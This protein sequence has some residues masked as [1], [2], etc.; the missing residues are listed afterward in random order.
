MMQP[1]F[2]AVTVAVAAGFILIK[3]P[4]VLKIKPVG[5]AVGVSIGVGASVGILAFLY[6]TV[7]ATPFVRSMTNSA[8]LKQASDGAPSLSSTGERANEAAK[9]EIAEKPFV[10]LLILSALTV[11]FAHGANDVGNAVG[12]LA[13]IFEATINGSI[14]AKPE[15]PLWVL[16]IGSAGFVV[17]IAALGSRTIATV[18]GK[19]TTLTPSKSFSV[20]IGAAVAVLSSTVLGLAVSTSHCL[21]GSVIGVGIASK[22]SQG[23]GNLNMNMLLKIF[24][25]W[26]VTIPLAM[27]VAVIFYFIIYPYYEY[28]PAQLAALDAQGDNATCY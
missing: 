2:I 26:G 23:G 22:I 9:L 15:I 7:K 8:I 1:F 11:A 21:V 3:G 17:G 5:N 27:L 10:P 28:T 14:A 6:R 18:G 4:D 13:A 16:A 12:P 25:G 20:Q 24:I 19:I